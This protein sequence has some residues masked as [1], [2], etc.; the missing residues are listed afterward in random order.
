MGNSLGSMAY[1]YSG[2]REN[3]YRPPRPLIVP[4]PPRGDD[5]IDEDDEDEYHTSLIDCAVS[6]V[7]SCCMCC[8]E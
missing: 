6:P 2:G 7:A 5:S 3:V 1:A 4:S 8:G